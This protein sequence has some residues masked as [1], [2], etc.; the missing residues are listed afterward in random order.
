M[1]FRK[2]GR[3]SRNV[4]FM[5]KGRELDIVDRFTYLGIVFTPGGSFS[6]TFDA[7]SG[8]A[9]KAVFRLK[10]CISKY[11]C[12]SIKHRL[13]L[14][15][16]LI[17]PVL[18]YGS[19]IWGLSNSLQIER[20]HLRFCKELLGVRLQTQ[21][22]FVYGELGR[23]SLLC[24]RSINV[25]RYWLKIVTMETVKYVKLMYDKLCMHLEEN[26]HFKSWAYNV[27]QL[28][29]ALGFNDVWLSQGVGDIN[30]FLNMFKRR[31]T[32]NYIQIWQSELRES[33]R[34]RNYVHVSF[35]ELQPY[36]CNVNITKYRYAL[37]RLRM[38]S[39]MLSIETGRWH[40]PT[41]TP[42][43]ERTCL[44][45][46][47][48]EDEYHFLLECQLY[49]E[50]REMYIKPYYFKRRNMFKFIELMTSQKAVVNRNLAMYVYKAFELR[51]TFHMYY[52]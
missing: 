34:A 9:L 23:T 24:K 40:K 49:A 2:G 36:L 31:A 21:N 11:P 42:Y 1:V 50:L 19:E 4:K 12:I 37:S 15:D 5:Y 39:H 29:Q 22:N 41:A 10:S 48:L 46:N 3:L 28:L 25:I 18:S 52:E 7:L 33:S 27:R 6:K 51:K 47:T 16:K 13:D 26:P 43:N 20:I 14:F 17:Y 8:Q 30:L 32:D 44:F 35:I 45:C 38:S